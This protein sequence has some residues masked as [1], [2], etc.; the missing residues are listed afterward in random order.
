MLIARA[1]PSIGSVPLPISSNKTKDLLVTLFKISMIFDKCEE[2][3]DKLF[4]KRSFLETFL[5]L[6]LNGKI[7]I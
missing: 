3:V 4:V 2:N 7:L 5:F 6:S 1:E